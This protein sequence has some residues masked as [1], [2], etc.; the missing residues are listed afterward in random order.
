MIFIGLSKARIHLTHLSLS[1]AKL[2]SK[3]RIHLIT[4][5]ENIHINMVYTSCLSCCQMTYNFGSQE[6]RKC[7]EIIKASWNYSLVLSLPFQNDFF[8]QYQQKTAE[9]QKLS[10]FCSSLFDMKTRVCLKYF[11][12][13]CIWK[14]YLTCP[15]PLQT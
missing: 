6:I 2:N 15:R 8:F 7:Q 12:L 13:N 1:L 3:V 9:K 14:L 11:V 10:F 5:R 4:R